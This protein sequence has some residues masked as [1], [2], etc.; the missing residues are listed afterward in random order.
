MGVPVLVLKI[1]NS[2]PLGSPLVLNI[3]AFFGVLKWFLKIFIFKTSTVSTL[4]TSRCFAFYILG[5]LFPSYYEFTMPPVF[6]SRFLKFKKAIFG[7][8]G[9]KRP[10]GPS[11]IWEKLFPAL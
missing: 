4:G 1:K 5:Q 11:K 3:L 9:L 6:S 2:E 8:F 7:I 10:F